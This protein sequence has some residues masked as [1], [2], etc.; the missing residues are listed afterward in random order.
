M[1]D[2]LITQT[3]FTDSCLRFEGDL[4]YMVRAMNL[5]QTPSGSYFNMSQGT[6]TTINHVGT[7]D[8]TAA[9]TFTSEGQVVS[10]TNNSNGSVEHYLWLFGDGAISE[11]Q[12]PVHHYEDGLF[13]ATLIVSNACKSDTVDMEILILT[14]TKDIRDDE[15]VTISPNPTDGSFSVTMKEDVQSPF[16]LDLY[17]SDGSLVF[18]KKDVISNEFVPLPGLDAGVYTLLIT[19]HNQQFRKKLVLIK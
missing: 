16:H 10:F 1:N 2:S 17:A 9:A 18:E 6:A 19:Q 4:T 5:Q 3:E 7:P 11:E 13:V 12:N 15:T 8:L 14:G